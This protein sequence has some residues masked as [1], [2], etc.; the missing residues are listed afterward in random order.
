[1]SYEYESSFC[2]SKSLELFF[3]TKRKP[4]CLKRDYCSIIWWQAC[5]NRGS[6][7]VWRDYCSIIWGQAC[8]NRGRLSVWRDYCSIIWWQACCNRGSLSVWRDYC[9][10]IWW[11][12]CFD[13]GSLV[14][15]ETIVKLY[16]SLVFEETIVLLYGGKLVLTE[17]SQVFGETIVLLYGGKPVSTEGRLSVWRNYC[18][19]IWWQACVDR[20]RL[21]VRD[22]C[23]IGMV[24]SLFDRGRLSVWRDYCAIIWCRKLVS[25]KLCYYSVQAVVKGKPMSERDIVLL[26]GG[27]GQVLLYGFVTEDK[28]LERLLCWWQ[29]PILERLLCYM[30]ASLSGETIVLLYGGKLVVTEEAVWR[31]YCAIIWRQACCVQREA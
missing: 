31:D 2:Y 19:I 15:E 27:V 21:S 30:V 22:Y 18:A 10:F 17:G 25:D 8:C 29:R 20:G 3:T 16:G 23:A 5:S 6:L 14:F 7:S 4:Q 24:A 9:A 11:Q 1:M 12:A 26:Y 28:C 13:I